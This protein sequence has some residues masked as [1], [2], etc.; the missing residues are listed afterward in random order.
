VP[1]NNKND[2]RRGGAGGSNPHS[3]SGILVSE[4]STMAGEREQTGPLLAFDVGNTSVKAALRTADGWHQVCR[5]ATQPTESVGQ[6]LAGAFPDD[7]LDSAREGRCVACS[8]QPAANGALKSFWREAGGAGEV[9][10]FGAGLPIPIETCLR[11]PEK[12]GPDRLLLALGARALHGAPC[13]VVS[14]GTAITVDWVDAE[15]RFAGGAIAPGFHLAAQALHEKTAFLP[16]VEPAVPHAEAGPVGADTRE[17]IERGIY[18]FCAGGVL[19]LI[20][21]YRKGENCP[22]APVVCTGSDAPLLLPA[23]A[24]TGAA[25]EP[26][27]L[28]RGMDAALG[29]PA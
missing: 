15:G 6:R 10:F 21:R 20:S 8:V 14:A 28:F 29:L 13:V 16:L 22:G 2:E 3:A 4:P 9:E 7:L 12:A 27:L 24:Q 19:A 26:A 23:L 25:H 1:S 17:A 18:W 11:E 5:V